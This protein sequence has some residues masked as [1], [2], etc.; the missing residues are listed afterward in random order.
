MLFILLL[1]DRLVE[2]ESFEFWRFFVFD[3]LDELFRFGVFVKE[4]GFL[5]F[6]NF[7]E[8]INFDVVDIFV[9][10][11]NLFEFER[12]DIDNFV[13]FMDDRIEGFLL[14]LDIFFRSFDE[15]LSLVELLSID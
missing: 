14:R 10:F 5:E 8:F 15:L 7:E 1:F 13:V 11:V 4:D 6:D 12:F 3:N 2:L 9:E